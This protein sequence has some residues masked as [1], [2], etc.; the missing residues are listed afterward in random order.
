MTTHE[1]VDFEIEHG[2]GFTPQPEQA[3]EFDRGEWTEEGW[4]K[5]REAG[6]CYTLL[7]GDLVVA[8]G[9]VLP[10]WHG[11]AVAWSYASDQMGRDD[12]FAAHDLLP[13]LFD[14]IQTDEK[15]RRLEANICNNF[16]AAH[17]WSVMLGF[18]FECVMRKYSP[19]GTDYAL[20]ARIR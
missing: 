12:L 11:R 4:R 9:G 8:I 16:S 1:L 17:R 14:G 13:K 2:L 19:D 5:V 6:P 3:V 18:E 7:R 15:Y 10:I 20:Y